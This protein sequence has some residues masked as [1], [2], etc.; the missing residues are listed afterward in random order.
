[1]RFV[2][3]EEDVS[4]YGITLGKKRIMEIERGSTRFHSVE[5][6]IWKRLW[7]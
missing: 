5:N 2:K 1:V 7:N 6:L 3:E 4:S